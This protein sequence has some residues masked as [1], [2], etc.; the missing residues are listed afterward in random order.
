MWC[1]IAVFIGIGLIVIALVMASD[2]EDDDLTAR[3]ED[4]R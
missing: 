1:P 2:D 4:Y 3:F